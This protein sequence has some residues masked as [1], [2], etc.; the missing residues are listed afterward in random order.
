MNFTGPTVDFL[1]ERKAYRICR[2]LPEREFVEFCRARGVSI[3]ADRLRRLEKL[4]L[5]FP[6]MRA[7][8]H[9][10]TVKVEY[11]EDRTRYRDLGPLAEGE[12]WGGDVIV[13]LAQFSFGSK[14]I[15]SWR[16]HGSVW[17]PQTEANPHADSI[18]KEPRRH[19]A[20]YSIFQINT[21]LFLLSELNFTIQIESYIEDD[22]KTPSRLNINK[23]TL[24][25]HIHWLV[26]RENPVGLR[27]DTSFLCQIISNRYYP[28]T[29]SDERRFVLTSGAIEH[30]EWDW[31][32]YARAWD[33][34][35]ILNQLGWSRDA[36][37][38][39]YEA[40]SV[41]LTSVDPLAEWQNL[42]RFIAVDK[43][44]RLKGKA[45]LAQTLREMAVML[46]LLYRDA[47][48]EDLP[49]PYEVFT[50]VFHRIPDVEPSIDPL[51]A[52]ELVA[53][54]FHVNPKPRLVLFVEGETEAAIIPL[55]FDRLLGANP[56]K[57]EIEIINLKGISNITGGKSESLSSIWRL[58]D[59]FHHHQT[60]AVVLADNEGW[61]S[62][63]LKR[64]L[65]NSI[66][67][68]FSDRKTTRP[69]YIRVWRLCFELDNFSDT[70]ISAA[71]IEMGAQVSKLEITKCRND[72]RFP[73]HDK[74]ATT[75][76][77]IFKDK[78]GR[79]LDKVALGRTL[80]EMMFRTSTKRSPSNRPISK[81]ILRVAKLSARN[82][83]PATNSMWEYNQ[84]SGFLGTLRPGAV[85]KRKDPF[86]RARR[87]RRPKRAP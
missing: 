11:L 71:L 48:E 9:D 26:S 62:K 32:E 87:R 64:G 31:Y 20:Y 1:I 77:S 28:K 68:Y 72:A 65:R 25:E 69:N 22:R 21:L 70:E 55:V 2:L 27:D 58:V 6:I 4:R 13:E 74:K 73:A 81:F 59:Y 16:E 83:Q 45:L 15:R 82:H 10:V 40:I 75:I 49:P 47:Y 42:V 7:Y 43:K 46:R 39:Q 41:E 78:T 37:K 63:N 29:Q 34:S 61:A 19:T 57:F 52:L 56:S 30:G 8:F 17:D 35:A 76:A 18:D 54:D 50:Q 33:G 14:H 3:S 23:K 24:F 53:N 51:R 84:R 66:S 12:S 67:T 79:G 44:A 5:F 86:G 85:A 36:L 80:I 38:S 60:I